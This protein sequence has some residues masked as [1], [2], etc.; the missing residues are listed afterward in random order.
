[1]PP[2]PAAKEG[3]KGGQKGSPV[4]PI[5][6]TKK[7]LE[8]QKLLIMAQAKSEL[9]LAANWSRHMQASMAREVYARM[10][11]DY[12]QEMATTLQRVWRGHGPRSLM[13]TF[14]FAGHARAATKLSAVYR[15]H[16][17][18]VRTRMGYNPKCEAA[19]RVLQKS[20]RSSVTRDILKVTPTPCTIRMLP[21]RCGH[22]QWCGFAACMTSARP[23]VG[24]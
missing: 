8:E 17:A 4:K 16:V 1:M 22:C 2:K 3:Q 19:A 10:K 20:Y 9:W 24:L 18:R 23:R 5:K 12:I 6:L 15:A 11:I 7:Q 13:A 21:P 14:H